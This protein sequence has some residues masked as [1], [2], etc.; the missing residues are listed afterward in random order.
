[1]PFPAGYD[2][3]RGLVRHVHFKDA[4]RTLAGEF[5]YVAAGD[6]DWERQI[7]ALLR[8]GY[9]AYVTVETHAT[10]KIASTRALIERLRKLINTTHDRTVAPAAEQGKRT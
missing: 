5:E 9:D 7:P 6:V 10:P 8:D 3:V 1:V 4:R 2:H